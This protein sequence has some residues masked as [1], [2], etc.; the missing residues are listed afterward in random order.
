MGD[1]FKE[2]LVKRE[3]TS[4]T[5]LIKAGII[6]A[7]VLLIIILGAFTRI[8]LVSTFLPIIFVLV[9]GG[10]YF[11]FTMQN[12][13]YEYIYTNGELDID[14]ITNKSRRKRVFSSDIREIEVMA[15]IEDK[16]FES[17]FKNLEQT[18]DFSSGKIKPNTY[19]ARLSYNNKMVKLIIEPNETIIDAMSKTL[20]PR[21]FH[22]KK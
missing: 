5:T 16:N 10:A 20:T 14:R 8:P 1:I 18:L 12:I 19:V 9:I 7:A 11:L 3:P 17:E 13:E 21:K 2:Q 4:K 22:I 6:G 15:H